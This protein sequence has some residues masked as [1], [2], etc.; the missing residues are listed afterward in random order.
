MR[1]SNSYFQGNQ[2]AVG[3]D[4]TL[5]NVTAN[6][7]TGAG[8]NDNGV[9][10]AIM[11]STDGGVHW[12][13]PRKIAPLRTAQLFA[14]DD[15]F[16]IRAGDFIPDVAI[17]PHTGNIYVVWSDS[18]G[19]DLN[20]I[21]LASSTDGGRHWTGPA[22]VS[23][24]GPDAQAYNHAIAMTGDGTLALTYFDDRNNDPGDSVATTDIWLRHSHNAGATWE[25]EQHLSG[26]FDHY[27]APV[28][29]FA[30]G[31]PR[32]LF[33]GD[34]M[35]LEATSN[36]GLIAFFTT[37]VADGADVHPVHLTHP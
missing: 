23:G 3:P 32:G 18:L 16:P 22:V 8:L 9:Y 15:G 35:G 2:I 26:P 27:L 34:Y 13:A 20:K 19:T 17:D 29:Y 36:N 31:D 28:S 6:L 30:P 21:V 7:F 33:L 4:G 10:M 11:R 12:S 24:G 1:N 5:Y 25:P 14:P 37:T